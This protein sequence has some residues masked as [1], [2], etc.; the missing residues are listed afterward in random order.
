MLVASRIE[1]IASGIQHVSCRADSAKK[2][3]IAAF[4][5]GAALAQADTH[6]HPAAYEAS[7][8]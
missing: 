6:P 3:L 2:R 7:E 8:R 4:G 5:G 1:T